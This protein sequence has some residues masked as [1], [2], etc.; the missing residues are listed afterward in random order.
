M[1]SEARFLAALAETAAY[2][3]PRKS[4]ASEAGATELHLLDGEGATLLVLLADPDA[5]PD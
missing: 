2:R 1:E 4:A 5:D 3:L